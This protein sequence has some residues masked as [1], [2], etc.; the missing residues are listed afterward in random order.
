MDLGYISN[1][2]FQHAQELHILEKLA[3]AVREAGVSR[4]NVGPNYG[5]PEINTETKKKLINK[6]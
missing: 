5:T 3:S 6:N 1:Q 2:D 4:H